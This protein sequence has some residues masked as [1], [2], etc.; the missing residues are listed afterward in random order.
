MPRKQSAPKRT[1]D[2][3]LQE[4]CPHE[5]QEIEKTPD[6]SAYKA[7]CFTD[8]QESLRVNYLQVY[9]KHKTF[10]N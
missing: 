6:V 3:G 5:K 2:T 10:Q 9:R 4:E 7:G 8:L 1:G